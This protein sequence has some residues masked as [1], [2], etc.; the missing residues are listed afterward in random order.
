M[1]ACYPLIVKREI[2]IPMKMERVWL[3]NKQNELDKYINYDKMNA[4]KKYKQQHLCSTGKTFRNEIKF[5]IAV[6]LSPMCGNH[7]TNFIWISAKGVNFVCT[8]R[9]L[10]FVCCWIITYVNICRVNNFNHYERISNGELI[11]C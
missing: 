5:Q 2:A 8:Y 3:R 1:Y 7:R 6:R 10:W 9:V 11:C 4:A